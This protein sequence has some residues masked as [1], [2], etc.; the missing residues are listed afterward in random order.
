MI[1]N[2]PFASSKSGPSPATAAIWVDWLSV[3]FAVLTIVL[4]VAVAVSVGK[5]G[6][7][8]LLAVPGAFLLV[9]A[10]GLP[11]L[12]LMAFIAVTFTQLS[13]VGI[14]NYGLPSL[15]QP[16]AALLF[17]LILLR[18]T[19]YGERPL[20]WMRAGPILLIY[21]LGWFA[22]LVH[23]GDFQVASQTFVSFLKD[24]LGALIVVFFIQRPSSY[25]AAIWSL[26]AAGLFMATISAFQALTGTYDNSYWGFGGWSS[27]VA[28]SIGRNRLQGPYANPNAFAQ[29]LVVVVPLAL[30]RVWHERRAL[31]RLLAGWTFVSCVMVILFTY[32]RGGFLALLFTLGVLLIQYRPNFMPIMLTGVLLLGVLQFLPAT[33]TDRISTL[34][35]FF[36]LQS[37]QVSDPSFRGRLSENTAAWQMFVD[38]PLLGVGIGNYRINYQDY[39]RDI[40]LDPRRSS[41]T[42]ASLYLE[43][44]SEQGVVGILIFFVLLLIVVRGLWVAKKQFT[45]ARLDDQAHLSAALLAGFAGYMFSAIFKNSAYSNVFWVIVGLA[46]AAG[47]VAWNEHQKK[48][49]TDAASSFDLPGQSSAVGD[50]PG[51][52]LIPAGQSRFD[53]PDD[54]FGLQGL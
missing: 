43:L 30:D 2:K 29:V 28:G 17:L 48:L 5:F 11:E 54:S 33:Y 41:R 3:S 21:V 26:I 23:A 25:R 36:S 45:A 31:L 13:N 53:L 49:E 52:G 37:S 18:I 24:A 12:G 6:A 51:D 50:E 27:Q 19:L 16:L 10:L 32:S 39:S 38:H 35:Q 14:T 4:G 42:P 8:A 44:L 46:V 20:G 1:T 9:A 7:L 34:T 22:S 40:G 47:Q 15:A